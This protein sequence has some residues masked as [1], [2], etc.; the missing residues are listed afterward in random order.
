MWWQTLPQAAEHVAVAAAAVTAVTA[1]PAAPLA[2]CVVIGR[3]ASPLSL[4]AAW[5]L[6][7]ME[8]FPAEQSHCSLVAYVH[9]QL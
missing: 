1:L 7:G 4:N 3:A 2:S 5:T 6:P 8:F 9:M